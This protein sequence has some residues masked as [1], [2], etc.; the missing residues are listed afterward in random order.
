MQQDDLM[1]LIRSLMELTRSVSQGE[2]DQA[3]K[4]F[5]LTRVDR[6]PSVVV[7]LAEAFG[8]MLVQ[9]ESREYRLE[10]M[11][12]ELQAKN[13][14]LEASLEKVR[15]LEC[16]KHH[17]SKF[18]PSSV[19]DMIEGNPQCPD[20]DKRDEDLSVV[21]LDIAGYTKISERLEQEKVNYLVQTYFS[22]FLDVIIEN[23]GDINETAGDGLMIIF[24]GGDEKSHAINGVRAAIG[25]QKKTAMLND[26]HKGLYEPLVVNIGINSGLASVGSTKFEGLAGTRW[27]FCAS[28]PTTNM[29][30]RI[31]ALASGGAILAGYD[32]YRRVKDLF[33]LDPAGE[34]H[35]KNISKPV[36]VF[37]VRG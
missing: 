7:E 12:E 37:R 26:I 24:R 2:Y 25:I 17:L 18:V 6:F 21:F 31:A 14:E 35:L 16:V 1:E 15:M 23:R 20:L 36:K 30:A 10:Q 4:I 32:T 29:A 27:T 33:G 22:S 3:D 8:M 34:H 19:K 28:G 9:V 5:E 13:R 11:I